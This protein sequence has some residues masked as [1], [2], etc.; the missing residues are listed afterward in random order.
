MKRPRAT[1]LGR[2]GFLLPMFLATPG[3]AV[4]NLGAKPVPASASD[5]AVFG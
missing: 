3:A 1:R 5:Y 2:A 4:P